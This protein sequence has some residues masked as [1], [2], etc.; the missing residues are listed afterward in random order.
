MVCD[1]AEEGIFV[2]GLPE[3]NIRGIYLEHMVLKAAKGAELAEA[4]QVVR[5]SFDV[6]GYE[7]RNPEPW[8][9]PYEQLRGFLAEK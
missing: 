1:G 9:K 2:R 7:P 4:R 3:M 6:V 8:Q 5:R